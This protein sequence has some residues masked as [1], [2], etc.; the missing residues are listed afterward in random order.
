M[1]MRRGTRRDEGDELCDASSYEVGWTMWGP[2]TWGA[3][4][5]K[6]KEERKEE[7]GELLNR[8]HRKR[9]HFREE[10]REEKEKERKREERI[11][12]ALRNKFGDPQDHTHRKR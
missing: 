4:D 6:E 10:K 11:P 1:Y 9:C 3:C 5:A 8:T 12:A 7:F 2:G